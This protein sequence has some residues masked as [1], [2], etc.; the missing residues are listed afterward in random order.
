LA[1]PY[2]YFAYWCIRFTY[3]AA[4]Y[5]TVGVNE[6]IYSPI[7]VGLPGFLLPYGSAPRIPAVNFDSS[8]GFCDSSGGLSYTTV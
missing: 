8:G 2:F 4:L 5:S 3:Y 6:V 1:V 7:S